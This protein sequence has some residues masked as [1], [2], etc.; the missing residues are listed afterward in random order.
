MEERRGRGEWKS[1]GRE[2]KE[3]EGVEGKREGEGQQARRDMSGG[4]RKT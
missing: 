3:R 4:E 2:G 1:R